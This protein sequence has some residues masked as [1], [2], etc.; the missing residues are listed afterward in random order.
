LLTL[1]PQNI[2]PT[3]MKDMCDFFEN[4]GG[5]VKTSSASLTSR[6][7]PEQVWFALLSTLSHVAGANDATSPN[8]PFFRNQ[9]F[10]VLKPIAPSDTDEADGSSWMYQ[11]CSE[12]GFFQCSD[13]SSQT[14]IVST[15]VDIALNQKECNDAFPGMLPSAPKV[16]NINKY[17]GWNTSPSRVFFSNGECTPKSRK[18]DRFA[19]TSR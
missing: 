19:Y 6:F 18:G 2:G 1:A 10:P 16:E 8:Q 12:F 17:D 7:T 11:Y 4:D 14:N 5:Q 3:G 15:F 9:T 13:P